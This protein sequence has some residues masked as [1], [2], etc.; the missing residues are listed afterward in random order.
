MNQCSVIM[1]HYVRE[2]KY[3]RYPGIKA[4]LESSFKE[5]LEYMSKHYEF[6][7]IDDCIDSVYGGHNLPKNA[8][9]LTFDDAYADH[10]DVVFPILDEMKIQAC[11]FPPAKAIMNHEVLDVNKIHFILAAGNTDNILE[12]IFKYLDKYRIEYNLESNEY[13]FRKLAHA[14]R[15]DVKE[16]IFIKRLL[17]AELD[18]KL[19]SIILNDLFTKYVTSDEAAFSRE[20]YMSKEQLKCMA[21]NGMYIGSHGYDHYWLN[22]LS[23]ERQE[24]EINLSLEFIKSIGMSANAWV[25]CY[26]YGAYN[27]SLI[28]LLKEK[29]CKLGLTTNVG[30]AKLTRENAFTLER[31][32]TNDLPKMADAEPN[33]WTRKVL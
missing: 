11:F 7:S 9:L 3:S 33:D 18:E 22:T 4:L 24:E 16:V 14:S 30:I 1:Y 29:N 25:M 17:Q 27:D 2:L 5:Q 13:Y 15:F 28:D 26:P 21:R 10:F 20:L 6:V 23:C 32:D 19:R 31:L 12:D 8:A